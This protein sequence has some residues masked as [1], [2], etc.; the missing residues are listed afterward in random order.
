MAVTLGYRLTA[1]VGRISEI[2]HSFVGFP[3]FSDSLSRLASDGSIGDARFVARNFLLESGLSD[4]RVR[5]YLPQGDLDIAPDPDPLGVW[6]SGH[7]RYLKTHVQVGTRLRI[8]SVVQECVTFAEPVEGGQFSDSDPAL[9][10]VRIERL[11]SIGDLAGTDFE[12]VKDLCERLIAS[13]N[14]GKGDLAD[15]E[16]L[17]GVLDEWQLRCDGRPVFAGFWEDFRLVVEGLAPTW[18]EEARD[19]LGLAHHDPALLGAPIPIA[20]F[21]YPVQL[22]PLLPGGPHRALLRPTVLDG[23]FSEAFFTAPRGSSVGSTVDLRCR[24]AL[25]WREVVHPP[26]RMRPEHLW[27]VGEINTPVSRPLGPARALHALRLV[28]DLATS[29]IDYCNRVGDLESDIL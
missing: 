27:A 3:R 28:A 24:D 4:A 9:Y 1:L 14:S 6:A 8:S 13:R 21:R 23:E 10:L 2:M 15:E 16:A 25:P 26:V 11:G 12:F 20:A 22:I 5:Q 19:G 17:G 18:P 7:S 29:D